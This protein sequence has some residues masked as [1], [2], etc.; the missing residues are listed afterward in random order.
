MDCVGLQYDT[1]MLSR[2]L[3][4]DLTA[5]KPGE[6][7]EPI[8]TEESAGEAAW[9]AARSAAVG[10]IPFRG[11]VRF[12]TGAERRDRRMKQAVLAGFVRRAYLKGLREQQNCAAPTAQ[13]TSSEKEPSASGHG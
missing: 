1:D 6:D 11:V 12:I 2:V 7:E 3:G 10:W 5:P 4:P 8:I 9:S 13:P